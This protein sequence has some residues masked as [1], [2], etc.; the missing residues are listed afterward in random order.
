MSTAPISEP[1]CG[2]GQGSHAHQMQLHLLRGIPLAKTLEN[3]MTTGMVAYI[4]VGPAI[5]GICGTN[6]SAKLEMSHVK[7]FATASI[8]FCIQALFDR[9]Y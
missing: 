5:L 2:F 7:R 3:F 9:L 6:C 1:F 4:S 8:E